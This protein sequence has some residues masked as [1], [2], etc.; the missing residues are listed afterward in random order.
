MPVRN[1]TGHPPLS[2]RHSRWRWSHQKQGEFIS[3]CS[4]NEFTSA[5]YPRFEAC[6]P[7]TID[8]V[9]TRNGAKT[10]SP[11]GRKARRVCRCRVDLLPLSSVMHR[12]P[13]RPSRLTKGS[14]AIFELTVAKSI[15]SRVLQVNEAPVASDENRAV[16]DE[17]TSFPVGFERSRATLSL[18][19]RV[20]PPFREFHPTDHRTGRPDSRS[21]GKPNIPRT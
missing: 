13:G 14:S 8:L 20:T 17:V 5:I 7:R 16:K 18:A 11:T 10:S 12:T 6:F 3:W 19:D 15:R 21:Q 4:C 2:V 1:G 9:F